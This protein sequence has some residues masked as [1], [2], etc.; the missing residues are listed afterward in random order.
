MTD[1]DNL[2]DKEGNV[3]EDELDRR[4]REMGLDQ[5][6]S[7]EH[8]K[9]EANKIDDEFSERLR[10]LEDKAKAHKLVRDNQKREESRKQENDRD[11][12]RGLGIGLS[13]AY[14]LIGCPILG[15]IIGF[16]LDGPTGMTYKNWGVGLGSLLGIAMTFMLLAKANRKL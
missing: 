7:I 2:V 8:A 10:A 16:L 9:E 6:P 3:D 4:I 14:T 13:I 15:L 1:D 11:S 12:A 5:S